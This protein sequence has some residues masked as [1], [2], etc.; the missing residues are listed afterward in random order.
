VLQPRTG[1]WEFVH[2][3]ADEFNIERGVIKRIQGP[4]V[5]HHKNFNR[6]DNSPPNIERMGFLEHLHLHAAS[7]VELWGDEE[8]RKTQGEGVRRYYAEH[9]EAREDRRKRFVR[10]NRS[11]EF[12]RDNGRRVAKTLR[13][14]YA[15]NA[16]AR[17][18]ISRRMRALWS[19]PDY[20]ARVRAALANVEKRELTPAEKARVARIISEKS[21]AMWGNDAKRAEIVAAISKA[22]ASEAMRAK[23]RDTARRAWQDPEYRAKF[24]TE[25]FAMMAHALWQRPD[26]REKHGQRLARQHADPHFRDLQREG[27]RRSNLRRMRED[28]EAMKKLSSRAA[29][30]LT[31]KW[32]ERGYR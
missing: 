20:R 22:M 26:T 31:A 18:E 13:A 9:P 29:A 7:I 2:H 27:V 6:W 19:D 32:A 5:R 30:S 8:F 1:K 21:R 15:L 4:F 25:H 11:P 3:L 16:E 23:L 12:R 14:Y 10:Q 24:P 17:S 28:P